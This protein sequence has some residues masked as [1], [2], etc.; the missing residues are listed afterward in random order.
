MIAH[1]RCL[2]CDHKWSEGVYSSTPKFRCPICK[3][4]QMLRQLENSEGTKD[5]FG[6]GDAF[7]VAPTPSD[8]DG[9]GTDS[10]W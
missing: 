9:T 3:E 10:L 8:D 5:V 2:Y 7:P 4:S 6:Y 1:I